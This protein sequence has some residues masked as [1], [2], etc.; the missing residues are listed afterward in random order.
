MSLHERAWCHVCPWTHDGPDADR[1]A[2]LHTTS[3]AKGHIQHPTGSST[4]PRD[5]CTDECSTKEKP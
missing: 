1:Q 3:K 5:L 2:H 4:H